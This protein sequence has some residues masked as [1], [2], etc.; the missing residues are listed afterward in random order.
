MS[1]SQLAGG[2]PVLGIID[3]KQAAARAGQ[4]VS[5]CFRFGARIAHRYAH[6]LVDF[7]LTSIATG[8]QDA[9]A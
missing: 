3:G 9:H 4:S 6:D 8:A 1:L 7:L 2:G 5:Q